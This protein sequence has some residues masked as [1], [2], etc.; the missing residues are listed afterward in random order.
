MEFND[1][2]HELM[3]YFSD[4][5]AK[6]VEKDDEY[7]EAYESFVTWNRELFAILDKTD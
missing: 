3:A 6:L 1:P 2:V 5:E 4:S 7:D